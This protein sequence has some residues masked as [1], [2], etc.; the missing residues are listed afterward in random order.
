MLTDDLSDYSTS[1]DEIERNLKKGI[2]ND[3]SEMIFNASNNC[4]NMGA[5]RKVLNANKY[6][7]SLSIKEQW[8][9]YASKSC[10]E[11]NL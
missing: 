9:D 7:R 3:E 10:S 1:D 5:K 4:F 8:A 6:R 11:N 2:V